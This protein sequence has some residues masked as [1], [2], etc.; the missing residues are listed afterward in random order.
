[1]R[2][3][4][5]LRGT[6]T[7]LFLTS[8]LLLPALAAASTQPTPTTPQ[9]TTSST[10]KL[11][12]NENYLYLKTDAAVPIAHISYVFPPDYHFQTPLYLDI[13]PDSTATI[14]QVAIVNDTN[15]PNILATFTIT[16]L[17]TN[18]TVL[19][20]FNSYALIN[21][22]DFSDLPHYV[23]MPWPWN[24][25]KDTRQWLQASTVV[26]THNLAIDLTAIRLRM[27]TS[28]LMRYANRVIFFTRH[29]H[30]AFYALQLTRGTLKGQDARTTLRRSGD[31][32]GR[33]HLASALFRAEGIPSRSIM[34]SQH[35]TYWVQMHY[36]IEFYCP[37]YGWI[38]S[39]P[40]GGQTPVEQTRDLIL[41]ICYPAD[42]ART[43]H[44]YVFPQMTGEEQWIWIDSSHVT[45][46]Y[47]MAMDQSRQTLHL[48]SNQTTDDITAAYT[49]SL[50]RLVFH[51]YQTYLGINLAGPNYHHYLNAT[52]AQHQALTDFSTS[53]TTYLADMNR[54][55]EEYQ[56]I[57]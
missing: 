1:M 8:L 13:I 41:R 44:D 7:V 33:S 25:P 42:E 39:Q 47:T 15:A 34:V 19:I 6:L 20:H 16:N 57:T 5:P 56:Q 24:L 11:V 40:H 35:D 12:C 48:T 43:I 49:M 22:H 38:L 45:P 21:P 54:A 17:T 26:Q 2:L 29:H 55:L 31:C 30:E 4:N 50:S 53:L 18:Q 28:N 3:G 52:T 32:P 46:I 10:L 27:G 9:T 37:G 36:M 23:S 14:T 51:Q